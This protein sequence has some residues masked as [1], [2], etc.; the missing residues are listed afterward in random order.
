MS[1][2]IGLFQRGIL[3]DDS[4]KATITEQLASGRAV[5]I[6]EAI[7]AEVAER[8]HAGLDAST[9]WKP[10]EGAAPFFH[11]RHHNLYDPA[12]LPEAAVEV[13]NAFDG[14]GA[15]ALMSELSARDCHGP[16]D[17]GASLYLGG[18]HSLPHQDFG[19][20]RS[21]AFIWYLTKRWDP[22][23]GGGL[24]WCPSGT[25]V[26]PQFNSLVLFVVSQESAHF[27]TTVSPY[28]RER[29]LSLNGWWTSSTADLKR[30]EPRRELPEPSVFAAAGYG[31]DPTFF[32][33]G[34]AGES[35]A[36]GEN[37]DGERA[38]PRIIAV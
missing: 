25:T 22:R 19:I 4:V 9:R 27:V 14:E 6:Q 13:R 30:F 20:G 29:R 28:A 15:K 26:M 16:A 18:D 32:E 23:W 24:F 7:R 5:V 34:A 36:P 33:R 21:V 12:D 11:Y 10:Y 2:F 38:R 8:V 1:D 17:F 31:P 37:G 35:G 3:D